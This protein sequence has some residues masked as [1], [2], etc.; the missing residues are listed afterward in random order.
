MARNGVRLKLNGLSDLEKKVSRWQATRYTLVR[1]LVKRTA[2]NV[3]RNARR[4][5]PVR[6]G[7]L[8]KSIVAHYT[9]DKLAA[10]VRAVAPH[11]H[12]VEFGS[13]ATGA[14]PRPFMAPAYEGQRKKYDAEI[15]KIF[16]E[17]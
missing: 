9:K 13:A 6:T 14:Q 12:L 2:Q 1:A 8:R 4:R 7:R 3:K 15:R 5:V 17:V 10:F 11:S 16:G